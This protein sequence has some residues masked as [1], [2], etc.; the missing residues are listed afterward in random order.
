MKDLEAYW[1]AREGFTQKLKKTSLEMLGDPLIFRQFLEFKIRIDAQLKAKD[2]RA[3]R[4]V[5]LSAHVVAGEAGEIL[6]E[7]FPDQKD[8]P[9]NARFL[10]ITECQKKL[11]FELYKILSQVV[12]AATDCLVPLKSEIQA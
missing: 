12:L 1:E 11:C 9:P 10:I 8:E 2:P 5:V 7:M 6:K 4:A 3:Q